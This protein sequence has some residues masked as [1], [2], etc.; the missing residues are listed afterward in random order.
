[1][2]K[3][4]SVPVQAFANILKFE[5]ELQSTPQ[6]QGRLAY[7]RS[8]YAHR[9]QNGEWHFAPSKFVGYQDIDAATY[10]NSAED[11]DG[12]R[13]EAQLQSFFKPVD[14]GSPLEAE[15]NTALVAFLAK[16]GKTPST[17]ARVN[18]Y[19][20]FRHVN[21]G[22]VPENEVGDHVIEL[23]VEVARRLP[24]RQFRLLRDQL[25]DIWS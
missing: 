19:R 17:K 7:A 15:L 25:E 11:T 18:V 22:L 1:M 5:A 14:A 13:T 16:Y 3:I 8:W 4:V 24:E 23:M 10:L 9:D 2:L 6:M 21:S 20:A 12:R